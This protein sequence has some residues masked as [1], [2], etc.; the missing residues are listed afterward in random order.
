MEQT[1]VQALFIDFTRVKVKVN[2][3]SLILKGANHDRFGGILGL[4]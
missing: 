1:I 2:A 3:I 4:K